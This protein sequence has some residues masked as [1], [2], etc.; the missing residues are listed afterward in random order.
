MN[1]L[2]LIPARSGSKRLPGKNKKLFGDK[3]LIMWT[4]DLAK[5]IPDGGDVLVSTDDPE[6]A[7]ISNDAGVLAPWLRPASLATDDSSSADVAIH[8]VEWY[9]K[10]VG[11]IDGVI[12]LQP[13]SPF[14]TLK[15]VISGIE[16][17][18]EN[19]SNSIVSVTPIEQLCKLKYVIR[20][21]LLVPY[22]DI[23][24]SEVNKNK[25]DLF[26]PNGL[27]Y[28][29]SPSKLKKQKSFFGDNIA[30]LIVHRS[31][32]TI[33]IDTDWDFTVAQKFLI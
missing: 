11:A 13:T 3:P 30:P 26:E 20:K 32:E 12:L 16:T 14:R 22:Q 8:A 19:N 21:G 31:R 5:Q 24:E 10:E 17:F 6:I 15:T 27:L 9:E 28:L 7:E 18:K 23:L 29:I 25:S 1:I 4:I 2:T 33:D